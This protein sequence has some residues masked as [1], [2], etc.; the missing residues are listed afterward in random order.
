MLL[1]AMRAAVHSER[2][3]KLSWVV[4]HTAPGVARGV[5]SF[6]ARA[7]RGR[8]RPRVD[9]GAEKA[10][11]YAAGAR[12]WGA[13][14]PVYRSGFSSCRSFTAAHGPALVAD[15][16][17]SDS[18]ASERFDDGVG[19]AVMVEGE[20]IPKRLRVSSSTRTCAAP[21]RAGAAL[22]GRRQFNFARAG[23]ISS[24]SRSGGSASALW[25]H[26]RDITAS[27]AARTMDVQR[28]PL[29]DPR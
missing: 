14:V 20:S 17:V 27:R 26:C 16:A 6:V 4:D 24:C 9:S 21:R 3:H 29:S 18:E 13:V 25:Q 5:A 12:G 1:V 23:P 28:P 2:A 22:R 11:C 10:V 15:N 7:A 19:A 8:T